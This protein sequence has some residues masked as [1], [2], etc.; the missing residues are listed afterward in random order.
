FFAKGTSESPA[1]SPDGQT[2]A[3][4]SNRD[5]YSFIA[6]FTEADRPIRYLAASTSRDATPV[7][8]P[9]GRSIA[10][11]RQPGRG[12][13]PRSPLAPQPAPWAIWV[14]E[15]AG[16]AAR[17]VWKSGE[18]LVDSFPRVRSGANLRW[19]AGN[20]LVFLSYRDGWPHL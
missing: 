16:G 20:R 11:I 15:I 4:V 17:E 9:D 3:F 1:W 12:G 7:W 10:F 8:S 14:A 18:T 5:D 19:A 13:V 6:L 2:L